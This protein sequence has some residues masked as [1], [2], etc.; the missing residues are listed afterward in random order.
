MDDILKYLK[1]SYEDFK[2]LCVIAGTDYSKTNKQIFMYLYNKYRTSG[3]NNLYDWLKNN[4][5][6]ANYENLESICEDFDI[7]NTKYEYLNEI[8]NSLTV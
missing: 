3:N 5:I 4:N 6:Y 8:V 7:S 2:R 1:I